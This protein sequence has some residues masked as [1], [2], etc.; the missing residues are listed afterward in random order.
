MQKQISSVAIPVTMVIS[1]SLALG[2]TLWQRKGERDAVPEPARVSLASPA[3]PASVTAPVMQPGTRMNFPARR[4][5]APPVRM[6]IDNLGRVVDTPPGALDKFLRM[7]DSVDNAT[8]K[9]RGFIVYPLANGEPLR[10]L[11]LYPGDL[12]TSVNGTP[13]DDPQRSKEA[14]DAIQSGSEVTATIE[15]QGQKLNLVLN[16]SEATRV[17][18]Q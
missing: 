11:G 17:A 18:S 14:L 15:R 2:I 7:V 6:Y 10:A 16:I 3:S 13:L 1:F 8:G 9:Q 4:E 5:V 12:L